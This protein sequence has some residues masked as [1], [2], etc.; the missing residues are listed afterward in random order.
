MQETPLSKQTPNASCWFCQ[1][2]AI[3]YCMGNRGGRGIWLCLTL[4]FCIGSL[5]ISAS[6]NFSRG[7]CCLH[8]ACTVQSFCMSVYRGAA[9]C[10]RLIVQCCGK[11]CCARVPATASILLPPI[12]ACRSVPNGH[13]CCPSARIYSVFFLD[14]PSYTCFLPLHE[15]G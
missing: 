4:V 12:F 6:N 14:H 7:E 1:F 8:C 9:F 3:Y 5:G 10:H 13:L 15:Y 11:L 2:L